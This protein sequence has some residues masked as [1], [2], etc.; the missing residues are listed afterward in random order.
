MCCLCWSGR[1]PSQTNWYGNVLHYSSLVNKSNDLNSHCVTCP[2]SESKFPKTC[3]QMY[4]YK[5]TKVTETTAYPV[6]HWINKYL[7]S[8]IILDICQFLGITI[9]EFFE[10]V[11]W[12]WPWHTIL[13]LESQH[14]SYKSIEMK[15]RC[16][17]L[18][19]LHKSLQLL[20][21]LQSVWSK[22]LFL[23]LVA[24]VGGLQ[25]VQSSSRRGQIQNISK[26]Y[27]VTLQQTGIKLPA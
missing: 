5:K 6:C 11:D 21:M 26:S 4:V 2:R 20:I 24:S 9:W 27:F 14:F 22:T 19:L 17:R 18:R 23:V 13:K 25:V 15:T 3:K 7:R 16:A 12:K 1:S 10:Y 8:T